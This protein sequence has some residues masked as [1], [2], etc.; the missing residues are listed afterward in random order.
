MDGSEELCR[1]NMVTSKAREMETMPNIKYYRESYLKNP[2]CHLDGL[3]F[4]G[5]NNKIG[6][7]CL[8]GRE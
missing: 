7:L 4:I 8:F 1:L 5:D 2:A 6:F 3:A